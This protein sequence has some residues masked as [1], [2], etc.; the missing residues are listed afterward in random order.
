MS[1]HL[2]NEEYV[3]RLAIMYNEVMKLRRDE[4]YVVNQPQMD[5]LIKL[6]EFFLDSAKELKGNVEPVELRPRE[7]HGGVTATFLVF[8]VYGDKV[9]KFCDVLSACSAVSIDAK[10]TGEIC[11]SCTITDVFVHK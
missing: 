10:T 11:I 1:D 4:D 9:Q 2:S 5:K 7:E 6:L 8:D 3:R